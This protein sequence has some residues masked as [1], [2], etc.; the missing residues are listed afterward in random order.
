MALC[1]LYMYTQMFAIH[2]C[3][4]NAAD[5]VLTG[6]CFIFMMNQIRIGC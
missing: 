2:I 1:L 6:S 3:T 4:Q 5:A